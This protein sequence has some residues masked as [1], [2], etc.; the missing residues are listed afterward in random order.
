MDFENKEHFYFF[1]TLITLKLTVVSELYLFVIP[2]ATLP[3]TVN[4]VD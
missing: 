3:N 1:C 2:I 4:L